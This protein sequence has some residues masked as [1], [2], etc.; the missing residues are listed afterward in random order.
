MDDLDDIA[1]GASVN[2]IHMIRT[3]QQIHVALSQMADQKASI[4]MGATFVIFTIT[5]S[6]S[7]GGHAPLPL[8]I[9]GAFAFFAAEW[10]VARF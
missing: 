8:M 2:G 6:Q 10:A 3:A 5:I 1:P 4:L 9:L 7:K